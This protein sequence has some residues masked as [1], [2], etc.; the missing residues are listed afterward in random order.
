MHW[1]LRLRR[2]I[3]NWAT[4]ESVRHV[5][6]NEIE[7]GERRQIEER[8]RWC[9]GEGRRKKGDYTRRR[10]PRT[11]RSTEGKERT[12][13]VCNIPSRGGDGRH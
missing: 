2:M 6:G 3:R 7:G 5:D 11:W 4:A 9:P 1:P 12:A 10:A 8:S 13:V